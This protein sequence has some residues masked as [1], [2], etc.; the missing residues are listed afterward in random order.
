M[1][2]TGEIIT[3]TLNYKNNGLVT[4]TKVVIVDILPKEL[5]YL[6][7]SVDGSTYTF[8]AQ[9]QM[10]GTTQLT[11]L[12]KQPLAAGASGTLTIRSMYK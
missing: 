5:S 2:N 4:A 11:W 9:A 12:L 3:W 1:N 8:T 6:L 10:N 7:G